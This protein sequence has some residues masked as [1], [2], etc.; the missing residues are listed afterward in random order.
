MRLIIHNGRHKSGTTAIQYTF[1]KNREYLIRKGIL[2]PKTFE[3]ECAHHPLARALLADG[4]S[5]KSRRSIWNAVLNDSNDYECKDLVVS[6]EVFQAVRNPGRFVSD[7]PHKDIMFV[8]YVRN[9]IDY[10]CSTYQQHVYATSL[11]A[12]PEDRANLFNFRL[13]PFMSTLR[14]HLGQRVIFRN[15]SRDQLLHGDIVADFLSTL[16][17]D[18]INLKGDMKNPS[19]S[20]NLLLFKLV[21]NCKL[22]GRTHKSILDALDKIAIE[23]VRFSGR[24][25]LSHDLF[26]DLRFRFYEDTLAVRAKFLPQFALPSNPTGNSFDGAAWNVDLELFL[27][28]FSDLLIPMPS[29]AEIEEIIHGFGV[30]N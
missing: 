6:S 23:D 4:V 9:L 19:I 10:F 28:S 22:R 25:R 7:I 20:G 24:F 17:R 27:D 15:F 8:T 18:D 12:F 14:Q 1:A 5:E 11:V 13:H 3:E 30:F 16:G 26:E 2:Y 21:L 29:K